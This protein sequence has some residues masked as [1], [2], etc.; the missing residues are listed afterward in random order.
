MLNGIFR[1]NIF[2]SL[3][4]YYR[5]V[6]IRA[7]LKQ[8]IDEL[9]PIFESIAILEDNKHEIKGNI[10]NIKDQFTD[11]MKDYLKHNSDKDPNELYNYLAK[12]TFPYKEKIYDVFLYTEAN[13]SSNDEK[14]YFNYRFNW[15]NTIL[16][17]LKY[18][19]N[20]Q[21]NYGSFDEQLINLYD[22]KIDN[23]YFSQVGKTLD[24]IKKILKPGHDQSLYEAYTEFMKKFI[25]PHDKYEDVFE[26]CIKF[27]NEVYKKYSNPKQNLL[28]EYYDDE[29]DSA[30]AYAMY[31]KDYKSKIRCNK[32]RSISIIK[33][34]QLT[35]HEATHHYHFC[36][37]EDSS[38]KYPELKLS[39][40]YDPLSFILE[41]SAEVAVSLIFNDNERKKHLK[42]V[43]F[44]IIGLKDID[45]SE[46]DLLVE[47]DK[48]TT[49]LWPAYIHC[50][51]NIVDKNINEEECDRIMKEDYLKPKES[52]PNSNFFMDHGA[53][54]A[55]YGW[56][57]ELILRY[58]NNFPEER[59][60]DEFINTLQKPILPSDLAK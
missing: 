50:C 44:P 39:L 49:N 8:I 24:Q 58:L 35:C 2:K 29:K 33:A 28:I 12:Q 23:A 21:N 31:L 16:S 27:T 60:L 48:L 53:Y 5:N 11:I 59:R 45:D 10:N 43:L 1:Y 38:S 22:T 47:L 34:Q 40:Q 6:K 7:D 20:N 37:L 55:S 19:V 54:S 18:R 26:E 4:S 42:E 14:D 30:E 13:V 15:L 32:A 17:V 41:G 46:I 56:G 57:K 36:F 52:W 51:K 9:K 25:I 3:V